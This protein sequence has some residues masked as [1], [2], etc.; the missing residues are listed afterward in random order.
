MPVSETA[1]EPDE[2]RPRTLRIDRFTRFE[3]A[4][5]ALAAA[6]VL[7]LGVVVTNAWVHEDRASDRGVSTLEWHLELLDDAPT[8]SP[9]E[10]GSR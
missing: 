5:E 8:H 3:E 6:E 1:N 4:V 2:T 10:T 7:D 9:A